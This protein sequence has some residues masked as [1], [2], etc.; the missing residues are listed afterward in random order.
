MSINNFQNQQKYLENW[1]ITL[2][3]DL[4]KEDWIL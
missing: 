3:S 4:V 1:Q 2:M